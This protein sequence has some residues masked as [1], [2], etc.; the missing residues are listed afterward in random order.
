M[1][2]LKIYWM[3]VMA[4]ALLVF[5]VRS[6]ETG[7]QASRTLTESQ[8]Y[9]ADRIAEVAIENWETYGVLPSIAVGQAF[10]ESTLGDH[11][12]GYNLWGIKSG[13]VT[14]NSLDE[15]IIAYLKVINNGYYKDAPF[16]KDWKTQIRR[17][18]DGGYCYPEGKYYSNIVWSVEAYGFDKYDEKLFK[19][20][21]KKEKARKAQEKKEK[22]EKTSFKLIYRPELPAGT[23]LINESLS[24][25]GIIVMYTDYTMDGYYEV[26]KSSSI[27]ENCLGTSDLSLVGTKVTIMVYE[28]VKG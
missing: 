21:E 27:P 8:Q 11:C 6:N 3:G 15:G 17:I 26:I 19:I 22:I 13:A 16:C 5:G 28:D 9:Y 12:R 25:K 14:Y 18:L 23:L 10:I 24:K 7:I 20:L 1:K 2:S 4:I